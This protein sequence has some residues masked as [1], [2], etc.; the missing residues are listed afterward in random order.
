[1]EDEKKALDEEITEE[2]ARDETDADIDDFI[3]QLTGRGN[4]ST[5]AKAEEKEKEPERELFR[6]T[7]QIGEDDHKAFIWYST[8]L[9]YRWTLPVY[10][11]VPIVTSLLFSFGDGQFYIGNFLASLLIVFLILS[12]II[13]FRCTRWVSKI[14]KNSPQTL[15]L[16]EATM[17]FMTDSVLHFKNGNRVKMGYKHMTG[18]GESSKRFIMYFDNGKSMLFRKEDMPTDKLDEFRTFIQSKVHRQSFREMM[19]S[20]SR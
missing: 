19:Q 11:L 20:Q 16:T 10:I 18:V 3:H 9:R 17:V 7:S 14:K 1:M 5:I 2:P 6:V 15:H 13:T 8:L 4:T 12:A